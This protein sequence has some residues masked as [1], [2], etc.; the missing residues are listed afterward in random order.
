M[1]NMTLNGKFTSLSGEG[2]E[3]EM[4]INDGTPTGW[5]RLCL[6]GKRQGV[7]GWIVIPDVQLQGFIEHLQ[8]A[9]VEYLSLG[10]D[11]AP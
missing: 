9:Q 1:N 10:N 7:V 2:V 3:L 6:T 8:A 11:D 5:L 4:V